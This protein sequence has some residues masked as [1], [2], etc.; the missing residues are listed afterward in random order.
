MKVQ[1]FGT[2]PIQIGA[3]MAAGVVYVGIGVDAFQKMLLK[4]FG[5]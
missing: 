4:K 3:A 5:V 2:L 1:D